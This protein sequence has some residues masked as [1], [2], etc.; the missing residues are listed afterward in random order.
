MALGQSV[1]LEDPVMFLLENPGAAPTVNRTYD[2]VHD[3]LRTRVILLR[4]QPDQDCPKAAFSPGLDPVCD[5]VAEQRVL[6][7][8][9]GHHHRFRQVFGVV[10][11]LLQQHL[12]AFARPE[13][14]SS[15]WSTVAS[16]QGCGRDRGLSRTFRA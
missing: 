13:L 4:S 7:I 6:H 11:H 1:S 3:R 2:L 9:Q 14:H 15:S 5:G 16:G 8:A 10:G 12:V